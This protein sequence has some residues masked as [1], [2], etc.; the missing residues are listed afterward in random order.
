MGILDKK[1]QSEAVATAQEE[2]PQ[3]ERVQWTKEPGLRKLYFYAFV[4]CVASATTGYDGM[5]FNSLQNME[6]WKSYF[7]NPEGNTLGLLGALYQIGSLVSIPI[8]PLLTDNFGRKLPI[9]I[10]CVIMIVGAI[11]QGASKDLNSFMGGRVM[12]GFGNSLAQIA[13]PMLLTE[14]CHPQHRARLTTVYNC[15]WNVGALIVGWLSFGTNFSNT[16]WSWRVPALIQAFPSAIQIVFIYW[17]PESPRF[18]M[19]KD[20]HEQ[21]LNILAKYHANGD[22]NN[23]T[24]Q[25]E[26]REIK[27]TIRMEMESK[28]NSNYSDFLKTRGNRYRL[29]ILL[30]LGIFSQWSGNAIISNYSS[31]LYDSA[32]ITDSTAKLGLSAGQTVLALIVSLSMAMLV[33]KIGRRP[34]FLAST[35]GMFGTFVF[36]TLTC[37]LYETKNA[38]GSQTGMIFFI[39]LFGVMYSLAWSGLLVGY[40]VEILPYKLRA[41][42]LMIM[43]VSVQAALTL[44]IYANPLAFEHFKGETWK[45][46]LIY[47][48]WIFLELTFVYFMYV[49]TKGPTLEELVKVIDGDDADVAHL[50]LRQ[51][52][53]E[54][55]INEEKVA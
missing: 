52:E 54:V 44:N 38:P 8:V 2:A 29:M 31:K 43:N 13:S 27:E 4:L 11:I 12:L 53:K 55:Q 3:F 34:M 49:E 21:A 6:T 25:F 47:T 35:G 9:A 28:K 14:I 24:V 36:W 51:V 48:C 30:S 15:L 5:L 45:L 42:G 39:W 33:D 17:V 37:A 46:Y 26:Y 22:V 23:A 50:D 7:R 16:E 20:K 1:P 18:L 10:G 19:A 32:G 40:A 41:K